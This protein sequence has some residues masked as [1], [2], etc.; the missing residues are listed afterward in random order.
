MELD[1]QLL[2]TRRL[3][4]HENDA[5][6]YSFNQDMM[7]KKRRNSVE[8]IHSEHTP[9][10]RKTKGKYKYRLSKYRNRDACQKKTNMSSKRTEDWLEIQNQTQAASISSSTNTI[11]I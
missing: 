10:K 1:I 4:I 5:M 8:T 3:Q 2:K 7:T 9:Q 11:N 6:S